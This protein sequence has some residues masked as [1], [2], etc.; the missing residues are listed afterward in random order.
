MSVIG[1]PR[2]F[3]CEA[4]ERLEDRTPTPDIDAELACAIASKDRSEC[5]ILHEQKLGGE[6]KEHVEQKRRNIIQN[7]GYWRREIKCKISMVDERVSVAGL[8]QLHQVT[9]K[10]DTILLG[11]GVP[12]HEVEN[13]RFRIPSTDLDFWVDDLDFWRGLRTAAQRVNQE[14]SQPTPPT[15]TSPSSEPPCVLVPFSNSSRSPPVRGVQGARVQKKRPQNNNWTQ[16]R[17]ST[18]ASKQQPSPSLRGKSWVW[19]PPRRRP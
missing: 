2:P 3:A 4:L 8:P 12:D 1:S 5:M 18:R 9:D 11:L 16:N 15:H 17:R 19:L 13:A 7:L 14:D 6:K 10:L